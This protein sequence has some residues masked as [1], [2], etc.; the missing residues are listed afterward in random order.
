MRGIG[1]RCYSAMLLILSLVHSQNIDCFCKAEIQ[2]NLKMTK[3]D[4]IKHMSRNDS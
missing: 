3:N 2:T 4:D 1:L